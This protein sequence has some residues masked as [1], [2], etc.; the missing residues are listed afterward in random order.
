MPT[1]NGTNDNDALLGS[2]VT[3]TINGKAGND[4]LTGGDGND[5]FVYNLGDGTDI[6]TDF[7]GIGKGVTPSAE[8]IAEVDTLK[9]EGNGFTAQNLL[10]T[11]NGSNLEISF[12]RV[13][14]DA[15]VIL[16]NF[17]LENLDNLSKSTGA[18]VNLGN[19]LFDGQTSISDI[20]DVFNA[21]STQ[22]TIFN[23]NT[24]TF[25]NDLNN[26]VN[27]FDN[28]DDVINGQ[29]Y[30]TGNNF[31]GGDGNDYLSVVGSYTTYG[32]VV[33]VAGYH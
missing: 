33:L 23:K 19:I 10:L 30:S 21:N 13:V 4:T 17:V 32:F 22:S 16:Q 28:S 26:N 14:P 1:I 11:Q 6:I 9:F 12:E 29:G 8:V 27:G 3:D 5:K 31:S 25:L 7:G 24:V 20:F 2:N 15:K 18:T